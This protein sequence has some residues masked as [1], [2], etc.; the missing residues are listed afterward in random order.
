MRRLTVLA[1]VAATI[2]LC[3]APTPSAAGAPLAPP[4][5]TL[6]P[7]IGAPGAVVKAS[8]KKFTP[9]STVDVTFDGTVVATTNTSLTGGFKV[10]LVVPP[11]A[12]PGPHAVRAT[13]GAG[14]T[15]QAGFTASTAWT[16]FRF[17]AAGTGSNPVEN[18]IGA[19]NASQL[20]EFRALD[21]AGIVTDTPAYE[22]VERPGAGPSRDAFFG[23]DDGLLHATNLAN[24]VPEWTFATGGPIESSPALSAAT[25]LLYVGSDDG[26]VYAID[27]LR[28]TRA[29]SFATGGPVRSSPTVA[30]F[31]VNGA[32]VPVLFVGSDDGT[33]YALNG[34][35]GAMLWAAHPSRPGPITSSPAFLAGVKRG[36]STPTTRV[37]EVVVGSEGGSLDAFDA[38]TGARLWGAD[39]GAPLSFSSPA[40]MP[41]RPPN[42]NCEAF[43]GTLDG[44]IHALNC[45]TGAQLWSHPA[46]G[47]VIASPAIAPCG[48]ACREV[49][50]GSEDGMLRSF[51]PDTGDE[52]W[53]RPL[54]GPI[55][56]SAAVAGGLIFAPSRDPTTG[57]M[58]L[59]V[60]DADGNLQIDL[61]PPGSTPTFGD[62]DPSPIVIDGAVQFNTIVYGVRTDWPQAELESNHDASQ[63]YDY[64]INTASVSGLSQDWADAFGDS[65]P[66]NVK[67]DHNL[68]FVG[69][70]F[71][72]PLFAID[73]TTGI[74]KWMYDSAGEPVVWHGSV[75][76]YD[77]S[78]LTALD[79]LTGGFEWS[80]SAPGLASVPVVS[81]GVVF[82]P[83]FRPQG[84]AFGG[85]AFDAATGSPLWT[86]SGFTACGPDLPPV[87]SA[88]SGTI[89]DL[90]TVESLDNNQCTGSVLHVY[91][92]DA[93][94]GTKIWEHK[95]TL[96]NGCATGDDAYGVALA[97]SVL[98]VPV[99]ITLGGPQ[100]DGPVASLTAINDINGLPQWVSTIGSQL[101]YSNPVVQNDRVYVG[102]SGVVG[103]DRTTGAF[104]FTFG[105]GLVLSM[106]AA[107]GV[108]FYSDEDGD[109]RAL[110]PVTKGVLWTQAVPGG[111]SS[112]SVADGRVFVTSFGQPKVFVFRT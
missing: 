94:T 67:V 65:P 98:Y 52:R 3:L 102:G 63:S 29:W 112:V 75:Y 89:I 14:R 51:D 16:R 48:D 104:D 21:I 38:A 77:G 85:R 78:T 17:D 54:D 37:N 46:T 28:G 83:Q 108:L 62:Q 15:A 34:R 7:A 33:L 109:L 86:F 5:L 41:P 32:K 105:S 58:D 30:S 81:D 66:G 59:Q 80:V 10:S 97:Y 6:S 22:T 36:G 110:D 25:P 76:V 50:V 56:G 43:V 69:Q 1:A 9:S 74:T 61:R 111:A 101:W 82:L 18:V 79:E 100:C 88:M 8:G 26:Q 27:A 90:T 57:G 49:V 44:V 87:V 39:L 107:N 91:Q 40:L 47:S 53:S 95:V 55:T 92:L 31:K 2:A 103:A 71:G 24:G 106:A 4:S 23:T 96:S 11:A 13:D 45:S 42:P 70:Y 20:D 35:T 60:L 73:K 99:S 64:A 12:L 68:V 84:G 93:K 19:T 72:P